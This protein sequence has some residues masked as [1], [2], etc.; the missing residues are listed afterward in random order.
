M[1]KNGVPADQDITLVKRIETGDRKA[2]EALFKRY[3]EKIRFYVF[4]NIPSFQAIQ[5]DPEIMDDI[6]QEIC[7]GALESFRKRLYNPSTGAVSTYIFKIARNKM[8]DCSQK[9]MKIPSQPLPDEETGI[10]P[11]SLK[12]LPENPEKKERERLRTSAVGECLRTINPVCRQALFFRYFEEL[13]ISEITV[14][15]NLT[16]EQ[17]SNRISDGIKAFRIKWKKLIKKHPYSDYFCE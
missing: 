14:K 1:F 4:Y 3:R 6:V 17:V 13:S 10:T 9:S 16:H 2:E 5:D 11:D 8:I 7:V 12:A 15:L